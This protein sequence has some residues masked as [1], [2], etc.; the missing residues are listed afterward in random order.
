MARQDPCEYLNATGGAAAMTASLHGP[1]PTTR[2]AEVLEKVSGVR[3]TVGRKQS[4]GAANNT[5]GTSLYAHDDGGGGGGSAR[6]QSVYKVG[7]CAPANYLEQ[8]Q[9]GEVGNILGVK[10]NAYTRG[11]FTRSYGPRRTGMQVLAET[12][13]DQVIA[14]RMMKDPYLI[15]TAHAHKKRSAWV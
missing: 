1:K 2:D 12:A 15:D 11:T 5:R 4:S 10:T 13:Q 6:Y 9:Q 14:A 3:A 7:H 8:R